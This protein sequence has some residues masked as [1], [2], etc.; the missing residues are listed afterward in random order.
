MFTVSCVDSG[1]F[2]VVCVNVS[3]SINHAEISFHLSAETT[4]PFYTTA[5][6]EPQT[7]KLLKTE[8]CGK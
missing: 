2:H 3:S 6:L 8:T 1:P 7:I 4:H 5:M